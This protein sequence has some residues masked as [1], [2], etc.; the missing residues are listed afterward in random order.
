MNKSVAFGLR[1]PPCIL[2]LGVGAC[3]HPH[4]NTGCSS[5]RYDKITDACSLQTNSA[6]RQRRKKW[7]N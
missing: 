2:S 3:L 7:L 5:I 4:N 6:A 1:S